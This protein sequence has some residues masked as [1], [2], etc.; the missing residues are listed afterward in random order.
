MCLSDAEADHGAFRSGAYLASHLRQMGHDCLITIPRRGNGTD[1]LDKLGLDY[2]LLRSYNWI[3]PAPHNLLTTASRMLMGGKVAYNRVVALKSYKRIL[4][5]YKPDVVHLN[6]S[7]TYIAAIAAQKAGLPVVWHIREFLEEDQNNKI[8]SRRSGYSLMSKSSCVIAVS[9]SIRNKYAPLLS[10]APVLNIPNGIDPAPFY[11][12]N[13]KLFASDTVHMVIVGGLYPQKGHNTLFKALS[14]LRD[15]CPEQQFELEVVGDGSTKKG[16]VKLAADLGLADRIMF[17][18]RLSN[19]AE[20]LSRSD[21]AFVCS[22][23][24]AFGRVTVE[25]MMAGCLVI[26]SDAMGTAEIV[27][28]GENGYLYEVGN[29]ESLANKIVEAV[30]D[31]EKSKRLALAG[32]EHAMDTYTSQRN[33]EKIAEVYEQV[34]SEGR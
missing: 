27:R 20:P 1:L 3:V 19:V 31:K 4:N 16:L 7:F 30:S 34:L 33:A 9:D 25:N 18:G 10:P 17:V 15:K 22:H 32:Q 24:E 2:V 6:S 11:I 5:E 29:A 8:Y 13:R 21:I 14:L 28:D 26:G 23:A 12:P